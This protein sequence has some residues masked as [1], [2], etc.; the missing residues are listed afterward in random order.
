M[1]DKTFM[2]FNINT[3]DILESKSYWWGMSY[4]QELG[5]ETVEGLAWG[6]GQVVLSVK[7]TCFI[8]TKL[9]VSS[10]LLR[11]T[12]DNQIAFDQRDSNLL[13]KF[14]LLLDRCC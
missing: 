5:L 14:E 1:Q 6:Y 9:M 12:V 7:Y 8:L 13:S 10:D 2:A 11:S 4:A 3:R